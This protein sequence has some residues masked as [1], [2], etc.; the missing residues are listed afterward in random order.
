MVVVVTVGGGGGEGML[1]RVVSI[2]WGVLGVLGGLVV[3]L[4]L[5]LLLLLLLVWGERGDGLEQNEGSH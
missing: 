5:L 3:V 2:G 4:L 1:G